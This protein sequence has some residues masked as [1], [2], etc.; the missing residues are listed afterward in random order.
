MTQNHRLLQ[1]LDVS[2]APLDRLVE[3]ALRGGAYGAKLSGGG[4]GGVMIALAPSY[5]VMSIEQT[6]WRAGAKQVIVSSVGGE[7]APA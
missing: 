4:R 7:K 2:S 3:A 6:L 5:A 1:Q